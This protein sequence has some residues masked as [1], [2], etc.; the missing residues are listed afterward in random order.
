M[1]KWSSFVLR[2]IPSFSML[3][4]EK[5]GVSLAGDEAISEVWR[6]VVSQKVHCVVWED[7]RAY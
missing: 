2:P 1:C 5:L 3:H 7:H 4:A 6:A